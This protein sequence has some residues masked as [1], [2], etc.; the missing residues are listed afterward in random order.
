MH[1]VVFRKVRRSSQSKYDHSSKLLRKTRVIAPSKQMSCAS[2]RKLS[3][4]EGPVSSHCTGYSMILRL[5]CRVSWYLNQWILSP[6]HLLIL[7]LFHLIL[8]LVH[9]LIHLQMLHLSFWMRR[10]ALIT[11]VPIIMMMILLM[12]V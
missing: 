9:L 10:L 1:Q 12:T 4:E 7:H 8:N 5:I 2:T 11:Y 3:N 6:L